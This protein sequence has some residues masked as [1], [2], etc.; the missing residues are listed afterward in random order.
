MGM[1]CIQEVRQS[2]AE[3]MT[4]RY[5]SGESMFIKGLE[6]LFGFYGPLGFFIVIALYSNHD[7]S[8]ILSSIL[9]LLAYQFILQ[10]DEAFAWRLRANMRHVLRRNHKA[11]LQDVFVGVHQSGDPEGPV[12]FIFRL[13][14]LTLI[15]QALHS[16]SW[17]ILCFLAPVMFLHWVWSKRWVWS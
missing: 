8:G 17:V 13:L 15:L 4:M 16:R 11:K 10:L 2:V 7:F 9:N 3:F 6:T 14:G 12:T 5:F 1:I